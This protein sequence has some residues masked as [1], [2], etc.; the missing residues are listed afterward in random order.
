[1]AR[2]KRNDLLEHIQSTDGGVRS[3]FHSALA[4]QLTIR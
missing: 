1:M 4:R 2:L 3:K